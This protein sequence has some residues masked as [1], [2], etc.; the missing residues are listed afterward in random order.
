MIRKVHK[1]KK[2]VKIKRERE[3]IAKE[4]R[5]GRKDK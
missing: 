3:D 2:K 1:A 4:L 5:K